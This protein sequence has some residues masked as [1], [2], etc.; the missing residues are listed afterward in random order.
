M[1]VDFEFTAE[2]VMFRNMA[3]KFAQREMLPTLKECE[4][5]RKVNYDVI[6]KMGSLGLIGV[7]ISQEYGGLGLDYTT[8]AI[9]WEQLSWASWTQT[10][11][12]LG[13]GPLAGT[14][15]MNAA[16]EEQKQKYLPK[17]TIGRELLDIN[18]KV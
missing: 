17:L 10:F 4:R 13:H 9:I 7:Q 8:A 3:R 14:I 12:S 6:K 1:R 16:S 18:A 15:I 5:E 11:V 2:Q